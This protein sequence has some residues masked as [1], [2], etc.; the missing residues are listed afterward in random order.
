MKTKFAIFCVGSFIPLSAFSATVNIS[1]ANVSPNLGTYTTVTDEAG[2]ALSVGNRILIG[3]FDTSSAASATDFFN[4]YDKSLDGLN[5]MM[6]SFVEFAPAVVKSAIPT[7]A[8]RVNVTTASQSINNTVFE[9]S[10]IY[11]V[12]FK[13]S[14]N[15][16]DLGTGYSNVLEFGVYSS[17]LT[18]TVGRTW[19]FPDVTASTELSTSMGLRLQDVNQPYVGSA[20]GTAPAMSLSLKALTPIPEASSAMLM[21]GGLGL[22]AMGNRRRSRK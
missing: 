3:T 7:T 4:S 15:V 8:G 21:L 18:P 1:S 11:M 16:T 14:G 6:G 20:S 5:L 2:A 9:N 10:P 22:L 19:V 17:S 12:I 13:T